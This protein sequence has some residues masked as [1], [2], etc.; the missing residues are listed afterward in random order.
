MNYR[1]LNTAARNTDASSVAGIYV[2]YGVSGRVQILARKD[3]YLDT[4]QQLDVTAHRDFSIAMVANQ[5][6]GDYTGTYT[7]TISTQPVCPLAFPDAARRRSFTARV[8]QDNSG[9]LF[10]TL[11]GGDFIVHHGYGNNIFGRVTSYGEAK[12]YISEDF[13]YEGRGEFD[14]AERLGDTALLVRGEV[15]AK[16]MPDL[17]SGALNG[18]ILIAQGASPPFA[19]YSSRCSADRFEMVRR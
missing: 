8:Q 12:F 13:Y 3:G 18:E 7:L 9:Q 1:R 16:A 14:I 5:P 15:S 17:I 6:R 10:V 4:I 2:L 11:S 19:S